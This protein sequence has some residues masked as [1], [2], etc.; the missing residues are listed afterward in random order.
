MNA[1]RF[2]LIRLWVRLLQ[3]LSTDKADPADVYFC[4]RLLLGREPD[5][6]G[7][8]HQL[9]FIAPGRGRNMLVE[10]FLNSAEYQATRGRST[11][12]PVETD[13]FTIWVDAEDPLVAQGI[14]ANRS[15]ETHVT[16]ALLRELR[17]DSTFVD[18]GA[19]MGWFTLLA[20]PIAR[21][22]IAI[23]PNPTNVQLLYRS[24]LANE[25]KNVSVLQG[26][27]TDRPNLLQLNFLRSNGSVSSVEQAVTTAT[28]VQGNPLDLLLRET[29]RVDVMKID[30]EGHEPIALEG[31]RET[32]RRFH[33]VLIFEFHP[34]AIRQNAGR[35]PE[36][37]L[38]S[39]S[40]L[41]YRLAVIRQDGMELDAASP[42]SIMDEWRR[43]NEETKMDGDMH[44]D[45]IGR[46]Q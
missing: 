1:F 27:V 34:A 5:K 32:L 17:A 11:F 3:A 26:A 36:H 46:H 37:F 31:M 33:P 42:A 25:F 38:Q 39:L 40:E 45:L 13:R 10:S 20:A 16:A 35:D 19:N 12:V 22:V 41:G 30:I 28:I 2:A 7:W 15:Y 8:D 29:E 44:L 23:E 4:Y 14:M 24:L 9:K 21:R 18:V 43:V 6:S